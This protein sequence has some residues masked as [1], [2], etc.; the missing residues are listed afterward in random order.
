MLRPE[1]A[2]CNSLYSSSGLVTLYI[3]VSPII[4][5]EHIPLSTKETVAPW[6]T[7]SEFLEVIAYLHS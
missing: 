1:D 5:N 7:I 6:E 3:G 4:L 2:D